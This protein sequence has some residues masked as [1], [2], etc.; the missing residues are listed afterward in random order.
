MSSANVFLAAGAY[1]DDTVP[2]SKYIFY[3]ITLIGRMVQGVADSL[4]CIAIPSLVAI[5][6]P[7]NN[8]LY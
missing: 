8:E 6:F 3:G 7:S 1:L 4:I 2:K 5:E